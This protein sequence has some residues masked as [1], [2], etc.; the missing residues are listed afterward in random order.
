[1]AL[2]GTGFC[3]KYMSNHKEATMHVNGV[4]INNA[5]SKIVF[6]KECLLP[7]SHW[8]HVNT[9]D[10]SKTEKDCLLGNVRNMVP[11]N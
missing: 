7:S 5:D 10:F 2:S 9:P 8:K 11:H 4:F 1:M 3:T 6:K